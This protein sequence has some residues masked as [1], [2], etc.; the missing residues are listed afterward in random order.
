MATREYIILLNQVICFRK[1]AIDQFLDGL[2]SIRFSEVIIKFA[3][4]ME[5]LFLAALNSTPTNEELIAM[6]KL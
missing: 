1:A 3:K 6:L 5:P 4:E 2:C